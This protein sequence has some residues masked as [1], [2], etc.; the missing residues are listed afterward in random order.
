MYGADLRSF[1]IVGPG[2]DPRKTRDH[3]HMLKRIYHT[4]ED[5]K[6][7]D[8]TLKRIGILLG[9]AVTLWVGGFTETEINAKKGRAVQA[10]SVLR[11]AMNRGVVEGGGIALTKIACSLHEK[12]SC[13]EDVDKRAGYRILGD[14]LAMPARITYLNAGYDP[15]E[16]MAKLY[17]EDDELRNLGI[18]L[19]TT[20]RG[21]M[22]PQIMPLE[23]W[24]LLRKRA[25]IESIHNIWKSVYQFDH[26][27]HRSVDNFVVNL[28]A[29]LI[30]YCHRPDKPIVQ[31][32][33]DHVRRLAFS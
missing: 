25:V 27:R 19:I 5:Q 8:A 24:L 17:F 32:P 33:D 10:A 30:A 28:F 14:A 11:M 23:D 22:K 2:G 29:G 1:G 16:I 31:L 20:L 15:S 18:D 9:G 12:I 6:V 7:R 26:T 3:L 21:N 4:S 13:T